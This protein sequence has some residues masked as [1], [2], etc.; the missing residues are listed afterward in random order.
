[1]KNELTCKDV[2][3]LV[4]EGLDTELPRPERA[5]VRLHFVLCKTCRNV[6]EQMRFLRRALR[7]LG[8]EP[9]KD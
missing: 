6:D 4:S 8:Q 7:G 9:P 5:R 3:R 2:A 1:M